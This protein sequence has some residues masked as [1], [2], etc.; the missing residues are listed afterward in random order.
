LAWCFCTVAFA[1]DTAADPPVDPVPE[2][3]LARKSM[4]VRNA[5]KTENKKDLETKDKT[6]AVSSPFP[7]NLNTSTFQRKPLKSLLPSPPAEKWSDELLSNHLLT[8]NRAPDYAHYYRN[9]LPNAARAA[10]KELTTQ[11]PSIVPIDGKLGCPLPLGQ[12]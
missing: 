2:K 10:A 12:V 9:A 6:E 1:D 8:R 11:D 3:P 7:R 4:R 5:G